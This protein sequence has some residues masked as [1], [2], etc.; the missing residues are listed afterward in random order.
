MIFVCND[1]GLWFTNFHWLITCLVMSCPWDCFAAGN[2]FV[3]NAA[4]SACKSAQQWPLGWQHEAAGWKI[5]DGI[6]GIYLLI[7]WNGNRRCI[8]PW[9]ESVVKLESMIYHEFMTFI[10]DHGW[11][12]S[13]ALVEFSNLERAFGQAKLGTPQASG[14]LK[15]GYPKAS[16][17]WPWFSIETDGDLGY[18][19]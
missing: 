10:T 1:V 14:F 12:L 11:E 16:K 2:S 5:I 3:I 19:I 6:P 8:H 13:S 18:P 17:S 9:K 7:Y 4:I 15:K